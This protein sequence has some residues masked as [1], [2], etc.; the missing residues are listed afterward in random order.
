MDSQ[1]ADQ[2]GAAWDDF[3][4][5]GPRRSSDLNGFGD[6]IARVHARDD[7]PSIDPGFSRR[8][9]ARLMEKHAM[10]ADTL[11]PSR[12]FSAG[13]ATSRRRGGSPNL[14]RTRERATLRPVPV[15]VSWLLVLMV[16]LG[17]IGVDRL[18]R[19]GEPQPAAPAGIA[20]PATPSADGT[21]TV[22]VANTDLLSGYPRGN[23]AG[24]GEMPGNGP[25]GAPV[26]AWRNEG[27]GATGIAQAIVVGD[28]L[29]STRSG[30]ESEKRRLVSTRLSNGEETFIS[31]LDDQQ[32]M[33]S[34]VTLGRAVIAWND[35]LDGAG[36]VMAYAIDGSRPRWDSY[37]A[38]SWVLP[39]TLTATSESIFLVAGPEII[40]LDATSGH[41][42][43]AVPV[44]LPSPSPEGSLIRSR[45]VV[46]GTKLLGFGTGG[47]FALD[48]RTGSTIWKSDLEGGSFA[49]PLV[50]NGV[51]VVPT[52]LSLG[53][54]VVD[55][56][57]RVYG[58]DVETGEQ[59]WETIV[60]PGDVSIGAAEGRLFVA[61]SNPESGT[62][63]AFDI[64]SGK[65]LWT[66]EKTAGFFEPM[67]VDGFVWVTSVDGTTV[68]I[69]PTTGQAV[70]GV[71]LNAGPVL[72]GSGKIIASIDADLVAVSGGAAV[73]SL[74]TVAG[75]PDLSG[76]QPCVVP[77]Q[78]PTVELSGEPSL[79]LDVEWK[80]EERP[81]G[82][83]M[84]SDGTPSPWTEW[85]QILPANV[86]TGSAVASGVEAEVNRQLD[87][88]LACMVARQF[89][90]NMSEFFT[91]DFFR[92]NVAEWKG[93][94]YLVDPSWL[95]RYGDGADQRRYFQLDDERIAVVIGDD[96]L[97]GLGDSQGLIIFTQV[98]GVWMIDEAYRIVD[99]YDFSP[100]G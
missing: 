37:R 79:S 21:L 100:M 77:R 92:R 4:E 51:F 36:R 6:V 68:R 75:Y 45:L 91:D 81:G 69:D 86:P 28:H 97:S 24:T 42:R 17:V 54:D 64:E 33:L 14:H 7:A 61:G 15:S 1:R 5:R 94:E 8:L 70:W 62:L 99:Q 58:F 16:I 53:G 41:E 22:A 88:L 84:R 72:V 13:P 47:A 89:Q 35:S 39:E 52:S 23:A 26:V 85:P 3:L 49:S 43:W 46:D 82:A 76:R 55:T 31:Y 66:Y 38:R 96:V 65:S 98:D 20:A 93:S 74:G 67:Y 25:D 56:P 2:A 80:L 29:V 48:T 87:Q 34:V 90:A 95:I 30:D 44:P 71:Y 59:K 63:E 83:G 32:F 73:N 57:G 60:R 10:T 27:V 40:S 9:A 78:P 50:A 19:T 18:L 11:T 12:T